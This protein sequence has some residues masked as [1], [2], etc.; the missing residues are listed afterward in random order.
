MLVVLGGNTYFHRKIKTS[1]STTSVEAVTD[2]RYRVS[3]IYTRINKTRQLTKT[4][5]STYLVLYTA[6][7]VLTALLST[8][9]LA[10]GGPTVFTAQLRT[11]LPNNVALFQLLE[12]NLPTLSKK[13]PHLSVS[14]QFCFV[15]SIHYSLLSVVT[16]VLHRQ[17]RGGS[18]LSRISVQ[19][20]R[21]CWS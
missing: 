6:A 1:S 21:F 16:P 4:C 14:V 19:L 5:R 18:P 7:P 13:N 10:Q 15:L 8:S 3:N 17:G 11:H 9:S 20:S 2:L 12:L